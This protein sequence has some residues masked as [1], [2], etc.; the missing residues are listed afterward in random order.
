MK[1]LMKKNQ[2]IEPEFTEEAPDPNRINKEF[3]KNY[4]RMISEYKSYSP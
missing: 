2:M 3:R 1:V 4:D